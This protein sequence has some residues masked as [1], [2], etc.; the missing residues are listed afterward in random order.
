ML[1]R[2]MSCTFELT[3]HFNAVHATQVM[4]TGLLSSL[5]MHAHRCRR[6][7]VC[8]GTKNVQLCQ[9]TKTIRDFDW[10]FPALRSVEVADFSRS[11]QGGYHRIQFIPFWKDAD[12]QIESLDIEFADEWQRFDS[13]NSAEGL[14]VPTRNLKQLRICEGSGFTME[15]IVNLLHCCPSLTHFEWSSNDDMDPF[16]SESILLPCLTSLRING[17]ALGALFPPTIT[18]KCTQLCLHES[19]PHSNDRF[20]HFSPDTMRE[21]PSLKQFSLQHPDGFTTKLHRFLSVHSSIEE[22]LMHGPD[23][24]AEADGTECCEVFDGLAYAS[25]EGSLA[26][27]KEGSPIL[28]KLRVLWYLAFMEFWKDDW[29]DVAWIV[30]LVSAIRR[31]LLHRPSLIIKMPIVLRGSNNVPHE[32]RDL[33]NEFMTQFFVLDGKARPE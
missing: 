28:P 25:G 26:A 5:T 18:P 4:L 33:Q 31:L 29:E 9:V 17:F 10:H 20:L 2:S 12:D 6:I 22:M 30:A 7:A 15:V 24:D 8:S 21:F 13:I 1:Q 16:E 23:C 11:E 3:I 14:H 32:F 19:T 27:S